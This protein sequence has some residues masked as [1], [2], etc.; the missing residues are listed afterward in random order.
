MIRQGPIRRWPDAGSYAA[1]IAKRLRAQQEMYP[2]VIESIECDLPPEDTSKADFN[3]EIES[4]VRGWEQ[5]AE[6]SR[7]AGDEKQA[8]FYELKALGITGAWSK[9]EIREYFSL[10]ETLRSGKVP[11]RKNNRSPFEN[12][13]GIVMYLAGAAVML[14]WMLPKVADDSVISLIPLGLGIGSLVLAFLML[15]RA[16]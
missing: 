13:L 14:G 10:F 3:K 1:Q 11:S 8:R 7:A 5:A 2:E 16:V 6:E 12:F 4:R 15:I 9:R